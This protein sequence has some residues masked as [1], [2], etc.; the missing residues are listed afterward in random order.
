MNLTR[1]R[2]TFKI[3]SAKYNFKKKNILNNLKWYLNETF[4]NFGE[5]VS[6]GWM[7]N[8]I[9]YISN[10]ICLDINYHLERNNPK[11]ILW[12]KIWTFSHS[13]IQS[14][15]SK[16]NYNSLKLSITI[17]PFWY[18]LQ[19]LCEMQLYMLMKELRL[20]CFTIKL[21]KRKQ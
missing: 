16:K 1:I 2:Q 5:I 8:K 19:L 11:T 10:M 9:P 4:F 7:V 20:E 17:Q 14:S 18:Y 21:R 13:S 15:S 3:V 12:L 6:G